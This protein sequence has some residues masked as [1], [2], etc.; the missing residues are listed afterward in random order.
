MDKHPLK[1]VGEC[2]TLQIK[3][4]LLTTDLAGFV[5]RKLFTLN[6]G[7]A[8]T[9]Y[10]GALYGRRTIY[11]S[12]H[13][14]EIARVVRGAMHES[15]AALLKKHPM[16]TPQEHREYV[17]KIETRFRNPHINDDVKRVGRE[18]LRKLGRG[19]RLL[20]PAYMARGYGLPIDSLARGIAAALLYDNKEDA[21][22]VEVREKVT[23]LGSE[24]V[25]AEMTGFEEGSPEYLQVLEAYQELEELKNGS[26]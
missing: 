11:E 16:F 19:D 25:I 14:D 4:M 7:H 26:D 24:K 23:H 13:H 2:G 22:A 12:I 3:G 5:E 21:Q 1:N 8:I 10:L 20:G 6:T 15:G 17:E 18:P 9:A